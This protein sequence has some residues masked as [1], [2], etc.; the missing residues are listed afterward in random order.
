MIEA[1]VPEKP[2]MHDQIRKYPWLLGIKRHAMDYEKSLQCVLEEYFN[3]NMKDDESAKKK[4]DFFC[5]RGGS[6]VL[7]IE[8]KRPGEVA[9]KKEI[10]QIAD[11]VDALRDWADK[12]N[13]EKLIGT[14]IRRENIEGFLIAHDYSN[15]S[16]VSN[17]IRRL[18]K[19]GIHCCKW[20]EILE[21]AEADH[22]LYLDIVKSRAPKDEP[23]IKELEQKQIV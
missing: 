13:S 20:Y 2:N 4:P 6:D 23:R 8:L 17:E 19:D 9:G 21:A 3:I 10:D 7:V 14:K 15:Q 16:R 1:G 11:Y 12:G 22:R 18:E 5:M